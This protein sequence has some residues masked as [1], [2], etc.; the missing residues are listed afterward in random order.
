[1]PVTAKGRLKYLDFLSRF[2]SEKA[3]TPPSS[4]DSTKAHRRGDVPP[5]SEGGRAVGSSSPTRD[6][7]KAGTKPRSQPCVSPPLVGPVFPRVWAPGEG[8]RGAWGGVTGREQACGEDSVREGVSKEDWR[9]EEVG[10]VLPASQPESQCPVGEWGPVV[11]LPL[12]PQGGL[13]RLLHG[14]QVPRDPT[15]NPSLSDSP[16]QPGGGGR[17]ISSAGR[18]TGVQEGGLLVSPHGASAC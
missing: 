15:S 8:H 5:T 9:Q 3:A 12:V 4:G 13:P 17:P 10:G 16:G 6:P 2:S 14:A 18:V 11:E 1:M 7:S